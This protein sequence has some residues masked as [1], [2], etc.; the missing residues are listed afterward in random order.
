VIGPGDVQWMTS[1]RGILHEELPRRGP[2]GRVDGFQLWVNLPAAR[3]M[4]PPRYQEVAADTIPVIEQDGIMVRVIAGKFM[5]VPGPV[6][7]IAAQP[8]YLDVRVEP[9]REISLPILN[10]HTAAAYVFEGEGLFGIDAENGGEHIT[11]VHMATFEDGDLLRVQTEGGSGVRFVLFAGR[12]F[13][14]PIVPYGPFVM[15]TQ[16][17]IQQAIR[18]LRN[19]SFVEVNAFASD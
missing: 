17:E 9:G 13:N 3:K 5:N 15:N 19:G 6:K 14:E 4:E 7:E 1:G 12:P 18:D 10:G 11:S 16:E 8:L 2:S